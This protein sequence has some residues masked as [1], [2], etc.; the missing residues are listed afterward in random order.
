MTVRRATDSSIPS[1]TATSYPFVMPL[2][3][4]CRHAMRRLMTISR[5][6]AVCR[7]LVSALDP[8]SHPAAMVRSRCAGRRL[9]QGSTAL[10]ENRSHAPSPRLVFLSAA[11]WR[12]HAGER[13]LSMRATLR[14]RGACEPCRC[15]PSGPTSCRPRRVTTRL[16]SVR[17]NVDARPLLTSAAWTSSRRDRIRSGAVDQ[18]CLR[19]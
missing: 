18:R 14:R 3:R 8:S 11:G 19:R 5:Q 17:R 4:R 1:R 16:T 10:P 13:G 15:R 2:R 9:R 7:D 12:R 6:S